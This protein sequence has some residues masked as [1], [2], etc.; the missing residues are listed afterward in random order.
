MG[1]C[2]YE[3]MIA[4]I[5]F[6]YIS[7]VKLGYMSHVQLQVTLGNVVPLGSHIHSKQENKLMRTDRQESLA[8]GD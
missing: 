7:L 3:M 1:Q 6:A 2:K 8:Q 5:T 4:P